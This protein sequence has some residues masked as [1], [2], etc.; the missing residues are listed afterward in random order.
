[1][2]AVLSQ[3]TELMM[4][5]KW[6]YQK[7]RKKCCWS[8]S[9][10]CLGT[11]LLYIYSNTP[12]ERKLDSQHFAEDTAFAAK[13]KCISLPGRDVLLHSPILNQMQRYKE[14]IDLTKGDLLPS[15]QNK[16]QQ[17]RFLPSGARNETAEIITRHCCGSLH[18]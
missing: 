5:V 7:L 10:C 1:M 16:I 2:L 12:T 8:G 6:S 17:E 11:W 9:H 15:K 18:Q 14:S 3:S 4:T 13:G